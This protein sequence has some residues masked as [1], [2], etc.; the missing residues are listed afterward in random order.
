MTWY[1]MKT[2][3]VGY[4]RLDTGCISEQFQKFLLIFGDTG[5]DASSH[6]YEKHAGSK[7]SVTVLMK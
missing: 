6:W 2:A 7:N 1:D 5:V 4:F 3:F